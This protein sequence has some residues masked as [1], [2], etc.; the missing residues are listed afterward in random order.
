[1]W[2][3]LKL[4]SY[5]KVTSSELQDYLNMTVVDLIVFCESLV[6]YLGPV[7]KHK[8]VKVKVKQ[9]RYRPGVALRFPGS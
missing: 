2:N 6:V 3:I 1:M 7:T 5:I 4:M 9:S 8:D